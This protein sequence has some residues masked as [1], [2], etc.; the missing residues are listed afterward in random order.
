MDSLGHTVVSF[1]KKDAVWGQV[2]YMLHTFTLRVRHESQTAETRG[3]RF[4]L[5]EPD[6]ASVGC[7]IATQARM[8]QH[9]VFGRRGRKQ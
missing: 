3:R 4:F 2:S 7:N 5:R 8:V 6:S 9:G 1:N